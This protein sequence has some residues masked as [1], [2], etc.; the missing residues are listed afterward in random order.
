LIVWFVGLLLT[1]SRGKTKRLGFAIVAPV[2]GLE[3]LSYGS[4]FFG[5]SIYDGAPILRA[6][7]LLPF[8]WLA[9]EGAKKNSLN[10]GMAALLGP[11][12][13]SA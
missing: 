10:P 8:V 12:A 13:A 5:G 2:V 1:D 11:S 4:A 9:F 3:L 7:M 6:A